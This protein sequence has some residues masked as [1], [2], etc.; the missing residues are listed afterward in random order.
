MERSS[1]SLLWL[2]LVTLAVGAAMAL[3]DNVADPKPQDQVPA[4][5][6]AQATAKPTARCEGLPSA[7]ASPVH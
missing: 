5:A 3:F 1:I 4:G 6:I 2:T 7:C